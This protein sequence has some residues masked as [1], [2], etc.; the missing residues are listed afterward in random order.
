VKEDPV[1]RSPKSVSVKGVLF[2]DLTPDNVLLE[3]SFQ[4]FRGTRVVPNP[5]R[6]HHRD[7]AESTDT[8]TPDPGSINRGIV[9]NKPKL[10]ETTLKILPRYKPHLSGATF[11]FFLLGAQKNMALKLIEPQPCYR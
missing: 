9:F 5:F 10:D 8:K 3:D 1:W 11:R 7:W 2:N 6:I 4:H